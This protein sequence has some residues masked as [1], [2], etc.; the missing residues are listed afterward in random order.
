MILR[1][2]VVMFIAESIRTVPATLLATVPT[3]Q[4]IPRGEDHQPIFEIIVVT[5]CKRF[6]LCIMCFFVAQN[7]KVA[8]A[9]PVL[10]G[11]RNPL[12]KYSRSKRLSTYAK[13]RSCL[14]SS[15]KGNE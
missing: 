10:P 11:V 1:G 7:T 12:S 3:P 14:R 5:L 8:P 4:E 9:R 2:N 6:F 15:P 13:K